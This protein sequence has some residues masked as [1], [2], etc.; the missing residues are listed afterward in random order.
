LPRPRQESRLPGIGGAKVD[1]AFATGRARRLA[2]PRRAD[3]DTTKFLERIAA[4][5]DRV[6]GRGNG[7]DVLEQP[8]TRPAGA[9]PKATGAAASGQ[10]A[11]QRKRD[12]ERTSAAILD[13]ATQE[14]AQKGHAGARVD[15]IARRAKI[16]KRMLYHYFGGKDAL[17]L[18]V[19]ER[20]YAAIRSAETRLDLTHHEPIEGM[21]RL[22]RFTWGYYLD[23]PE[24]LAILA[25]ENQHRARFLKQSDHIVQLNS[26]LVEALRQVLTHGAAEGVFRGNIDPVELYISIAALGAFYLS[27]RWTLSTIFRRDLMS[28][29]ALAHW[30]EHIVEM[31]L[32]S[33]AP[34]ETADGSPVDRAGDPAEC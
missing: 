23:H 16:N 10:P 17:Y 28:A 9:R 15:A 1:G 31:T 18:A 27:N 34:G 26:P 2:S 12:P 32:A 20:S 30:G 33:L 21:R 4:E 8:R 24:F 13:A 25:T 29:A 22:I 5:E 11:R 3:A 14:F 6:A 7:P 19:L